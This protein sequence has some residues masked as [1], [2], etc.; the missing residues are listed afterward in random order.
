M[1]ILEF[2]TAIAAGVLAGLT[3]GGGGMFFVPVLIFAGLPV[4]EALATS[5]LG[6]LITSASGTITNARQGLVPWRR[7]LWLGIPAIVL[8]PVGAW[9]AFR[10]PG[11]VLIIGFI[12]LNLTNIVLTA[13]KPATDETIEATRTPTP[14]QFTATGGSGGLLAGLFG[15]GGGLIVVPLQILWL[16]TPIKIAARA[17]LAVI[18]LSSA[19]A[20]VGH[21]VVDGGIH[22]RTGIVLGI[23]GVIGAPIGVFLL[24]RISP[25]AATRIL[26]LVLLGVSLTLA[27]QLIT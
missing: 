12:L 2:V 14:L 4:I 22:W 8:A 6:I 17:S 16:S 9:I 15:I 10:L 5:N 21:T 13:R 26:Q 18:M 23:G 7:V 25:T 24:R 3:G 20:V 19:A 1:V 27:W 11:D